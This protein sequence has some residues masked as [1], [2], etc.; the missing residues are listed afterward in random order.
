MK[1]HVCSKGQDGATSGE[2]QR[3][4]DA[5]LTKTATAATFRRFEVQQRLLVDP[6]VA[7]GGAVRSIQSVASRGSLVELWGCTHR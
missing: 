3:L 1:L 5:H 7:T 6:L 4:A 2:C